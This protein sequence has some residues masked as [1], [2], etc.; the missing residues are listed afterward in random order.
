[1][2]YEFLLIL[3]IILL[4]TKLLGIASQKVHMPAVVGAL[5]AGIILGPSGI[6]ILE[7]NPFIEQT[8]EIG[9]IILMFLAG[10]DTD[11]EELKKTGLASAVIAIIGVILP[12]I[13][14]FL[15]HRYFFYSSSITNSELLKSIF[16]GVILTATSVSIT[17]E[18]LREMGKLKGR[19]GTAILGAA[20]IDDI[21]G[22]IILTLVTS[23]NDPSANP[24]LVIGKVLSFFVFIAVAGFIAF[25]IFKYLEK[26]S[27]EIRRLPIYGFSFA[28][29]FAF[30]A[31]HFFGVADITGAYF[32]GVIL[33]TFGF[34]EYIVK[35]INVT[36][37]MI[38]S[39]IF[40]ASIG[41]K[42]D[43]AGFTPTIAVFTVLLLLVA[44]LTKIIGCS[45]G[46]RL[47]KFSKREAFA[48]GIGMV[49]RGE[50]ALIMAQK[51]FDSGLLD[52]GLFPAIV[53]VVIITTLLTPILLKIIIPSDK[54]DK[55]V[56]TINMSPSCN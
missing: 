38:F 56:A 17:V 41:I 52:A 46:A 18:T 24:V 37:Y 12:L 16:V 42:T 53:T 7:I 20:I 29:I 21:I 10:L 3:A 54:K 25:N 8:A 36:S 26:S 19:M 23:F 14:G 4:S 39:P 45:I 40:F 28:L 55:P 5:V 9:V 2:N 1:M 27:R 33:C 15:V 6:G 30:C 50:V 47:F 35:K 32:A 31:E 22:V 11:L 43:L 44:I 13:G 51:G 48:I 34:K 49:S